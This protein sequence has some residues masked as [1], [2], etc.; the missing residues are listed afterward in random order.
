MIKPLSGCFNTCELPSWWNSVV[1][2]WRTWRA[3][4]HLVS[5]KK[6]KNPWSSGDQAVGF[7]EYLTWFFF[8]SPG[9]KVLVRC[10]K[11]IKP[12]TKKGVPEDD[13]DD[14]EEEDDTGARRGAFPPEGRIMEKDFLSQTYHL[15]TSDHSFSN[16]TEDSGMSNVRR[17]KCFR[18]FTFI[19]REQR[20]TLSHFYKLFPDMNLVM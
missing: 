9:N 4:T 5:T 1:T 17:L 12:Y 11:L 15:G 2:L 18:A 10:L 7:I 6:V 20:R 19:W 16:E 14:D 3:E 13:D 8:T